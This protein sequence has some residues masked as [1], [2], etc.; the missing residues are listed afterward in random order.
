MNWYGRNISLRVSLRGP[1]VFASATI[2]T[3]VSGGPFLSS[4][5]C[6]PT[7]FSLGQNRRANASFTTASAALGAIARPRAIRIPM[8]V[9]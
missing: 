7:A 8:V 4:T 6:P 5:I 2:P 1:R 3:T 9:K